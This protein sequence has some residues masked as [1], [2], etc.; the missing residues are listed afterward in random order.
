MIM[1]SSLKTKDPA[2]QE[3]PVEVHPEL[4]L[5]AE[6]EEKPKRKAPVRRKRAPKKAVEVADQEPQTPKDDEAA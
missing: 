6:A 4:D 2:V 5:G 1:H 3:Q